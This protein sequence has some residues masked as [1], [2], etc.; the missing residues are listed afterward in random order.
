MH[1]L[2]FFLHFLDSLV[3]ASIVGIINQMFTGEIRWKTSKNY[4]SLIKTL[5]KLTNMVDFKNCYFQSKMFQYSMQE[6]DNNLD[7]T[8]KNRYKLRMKI[9]GIV[10]S[11]L[12]IT[13]QL[14]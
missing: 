2:L 4:F 10:R 1:S 8:I 9:L 11:V 5:I 3:W 14:Y 6:D 7:K 12:K 13:T